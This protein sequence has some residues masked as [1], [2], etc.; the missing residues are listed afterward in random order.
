M[1]ENLA[2]LSLRS[3][4]VSAV[5]DDW[6]GQFLMRHTRLAGVDVSACSVLAGQATGTY[7]SLCNPDGSLLAAVNDMAVLDLLTPTELERHK[8]LTSDASAWVLDCNLS[9]AAIDW[10]MQSSAGK[11][12]FVDGVSSHKCIK[13]LPHLARVN[14]LKINRL[15]AAALTGL[16]TDSTAQAIA[17]AHQLCE[18]GA[19]NV[20]VSLGSGGVC[21]ASPTSHGHMAAIQVSVVNAN[22]AG[23]ALTAGLVYGAL[24]GWPLAPA[25][26]FA[27]A[28]AA[29]TMTCSG[30]NHPELS[31]T[32]ALQ[33]LSDH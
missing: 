29:V 16:P 22:G 10:I 17:A 15:E 2:R 21:W 28:C 24:A 7:V 20:V 33:L 1:A 31:A 3:R 18:R 26:R 6:Q 5:G 11:P 32:R 4:L 25:A 30:A 23:D 14:T 9:E 8:A 13:I 19:A 27:N 12:V